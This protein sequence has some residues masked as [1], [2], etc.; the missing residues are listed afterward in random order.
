[1]IT[2]YITVWVKIYSTNISG[3]GQNCCTAKLSTAQY[4]CDTWILSG[5]KQSVRG[6]MYMYTKTSM[7]NNISLP[8]A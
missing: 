8:L 6:K 1:M 3:I 4:F 2:L 7:R 5:E